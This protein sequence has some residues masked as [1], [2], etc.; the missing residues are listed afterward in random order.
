MS[1]VWKVR[2]SP[3]RHQQYVFFYQD[4]GCKMLLQSVSRIKIRDARWLFLSR[5]WPLYKWAPFFKPAGAVGKISLSLWITNCNHVKLAQILDTHC[6]MTKALRI[7][8]NS[9]V[10]YP[11]HITKFS[12]FSPL[13]FTHF[14]ILALPKLNYF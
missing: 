10:T 2:A 4:I 11:W 7:L 12:P 14:K 9:V 6:S 8:V 5:F 3:H 13:I 1:M